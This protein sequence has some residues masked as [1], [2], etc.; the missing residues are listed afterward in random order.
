VGPLARAPVAR[1]QE[2]QE[3][4]DLGIV[5][6]DDGEDF[7]A[8]AEAA[9]SKLKS[10][11]QKKEAKLRLLKELK[12]D[13]A[14]KATRAAL[15]EEFKA[16]LPKEGPLNK[17]RQN[18]PAAKGSRSKEDPFQSTLQLGCFPGASFWDTEYQATFQSFNDQKVE[19]FREGQFYGR[20]PSDRPS[21]AGARSARPA[22]AR[23][24]RAQPA[25]PA[26]AHPRIAA[27]SV[28]GRS[29]VRPSS[30]PPERR[31]AMTTM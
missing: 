6:E 18:K 8:E 15:L 2:R 16:D 31:D 24:V 11:V 27:P 12:Q 5:D 14:N 28:S 26:S 30:A 17:L 4:Q 3:P 21:S 7:L 23:E 1:A 29:L 25:R 20:A 9:E 13:L 10:A 19:R 22:S